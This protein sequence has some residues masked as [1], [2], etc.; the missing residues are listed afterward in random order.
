MFPG[1]K[2]KF[3]ISSK[4]SIRQYSKPYQSQ[5]Y[6]ERLKLFLKHK[7]L[8]FHREISDCNNS[9]ISQDISNSNFP[10]VNSY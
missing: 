9:K 6:M 7:R 8:L 2:V 10:T 5:K 1:F 4:L 3:S